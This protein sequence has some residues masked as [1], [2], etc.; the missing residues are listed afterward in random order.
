MQ[1][2]ARITMGNR[3]AALVAIGALVSVYGYLGGNLP[4]G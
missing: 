3:G 2:V 1:N 4:S